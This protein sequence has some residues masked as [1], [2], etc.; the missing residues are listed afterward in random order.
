MICLDSNYLIRCIEFGSEEAAEISQW[1]RED[2]LLVAP[3]PAW[4][5]FT[6]GP[7]TRRQE[8]TVFAFLA[9]IVPFTEA[10]AREAA[11]LY[12]AAGRQRRLRVDAMIAATA[13]LAKARLATNN[14]KDFAPFRPHG[15]ELV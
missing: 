11:R 5:E 1:H 8:E 6:C 4:Y 2:E 13:T 7:L 15:L 12:N 9:D 14:R 3:M 10:H